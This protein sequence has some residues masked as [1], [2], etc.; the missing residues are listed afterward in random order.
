MIK[1]RSAEKRKVARK[2]EHLA[3][4]ILQK[5]RLSGQG[6]QGSFQKMSCSGQNHPKPDMISGPK[7]HL[8]KGVA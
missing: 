7:K 1:M 5:Q 3:G 4:N 8:R 2:M 6:K